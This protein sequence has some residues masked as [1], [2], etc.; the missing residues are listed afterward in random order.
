MKLTWIRR[1]LSLTLVLA[2]LMTMAPVG[3]AIEPPDSVQ[4]TKEEEEKVWDYL[5][6]LTGNPIGAAGIMGNLFYESHLAADNLETMGREKPEFDEGEDYTSAT[7]KGIYKGFITDGFGYGLAQWTF[8]AR[9]RRLMEIAKEQGKSI[10]NLDVQ[11]QLIGEELEKYNMLY[12][13]S[14]AD[15]LTFVAEYVLEN[16]ENP[17]D[18]GNKEVMRRAKKARY[19]YDKYYHEINIEGIT[20]AQKKV[21]TIATYSDAYGLTA[22]AGLCQAWASGVLE[23]AGF[24]QDQSPSAEISAKNFGVSED[25]TW[26]PVGAAIYG[27]SSSK[28]GHVGIYVGNDQVYH[29][30][31][32]VQ[33]DTLEDWIAN[34]R[35]FCWGW[36]GGTDLSKVEDKPY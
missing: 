7:D 19:F 14:N 12:R 35:G 2:S 23:A 11:L 22:E 29:N 26:I 21:A 31:G 4:C 30:V 36:I 28:Y 8:G 10:A 34:Y 16:Y 32:G 3:F 20:E 13:I 5:M 17:Q 9:K 1:L 27:H 24:T 25:L 6:E 15:S 18:K 33:V